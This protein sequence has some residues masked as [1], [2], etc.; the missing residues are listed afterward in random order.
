MIRIQ[1]RR[2]RP[3]IR[4]MKLVLERETSRMVNNACPDPAP[5]PSTGIIFTNQCY[6]K[7]CARL[8]ATRG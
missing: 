3:A 4:N 6:K 2:A 1:N 5:G 8:L 7:L